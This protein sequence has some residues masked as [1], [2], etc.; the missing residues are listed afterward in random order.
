MYIAHD[1]TLMIL[2]NK[3]TYIDMLYSYTYNISL[4]FLVYNKL[5]LEYGIVIL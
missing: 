1:R 5:D 4:R 2:D 3:Q